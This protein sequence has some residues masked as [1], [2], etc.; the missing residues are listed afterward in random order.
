MQP[1]DWHPKI[2]MF[3][4]RVS[5]DAD[6]QNGSQTSRDTNVICIILLFQN[7]TLHAAINQ[8]KHI[9]DTFMTIAN[10]PHKENKGWAFTSQQYGPRSKNLKLLKIAFSVGSML[11]AH[12]QLS[13]TTS[14]GSTHGS[15]MV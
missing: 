13:S 12:L 15:I 6:K 11:K 7:R 8:Q 5:S 2:D 4:K 3:S 14:V 1:V 9:N 10:F